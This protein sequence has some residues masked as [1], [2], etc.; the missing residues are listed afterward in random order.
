M[1]VRALGGG[2]LEAQALDLV[3]QRGVRLLGLLERRLP[4]SEF[5]LQALALLPRQ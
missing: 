1:E 2:E 3:P 5:V 4:L